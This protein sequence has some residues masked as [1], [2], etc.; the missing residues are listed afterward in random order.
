[1]SAAIS[2]GCGMRRRDR[3][4]HHSDHIAPDLCARS[5]VCKAPMLA[6]KIGIMDDDRDLLLI[7]LDLGSSVSNS[8]SSRGMAVT[9]LS[10]LDRARSSRPKQ[11]GM[12]PDRRVLPRR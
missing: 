2:P 6:E 7:V 8:G 9:N 10:L 11:M 1:M 12:Q 4:G 3:L 5:A